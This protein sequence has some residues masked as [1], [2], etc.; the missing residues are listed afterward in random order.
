M[1]KL[2]REI[3]FR[4][5]VCDI[6]SLYMWWIELKSTFTLLNDNMGRDSVKIRRNQVMHVI[7]SILWRISHRKIKSDKKWFLF[8]TRTTTG[9]SIFEEGRWE[10]MWII[11]CFFLSK[12]YFLLSEPN[13]NTLLLSLS[14]TYCDM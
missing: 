3:N 4:L 7:R 9:R 5:V 2:L 14:F 10:D 12:Y 8:I 13:N 11:F 1:Q 6:Y